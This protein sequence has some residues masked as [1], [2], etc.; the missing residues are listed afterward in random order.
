MILRSLRYS[1][2]ENTPNEWN[3]DSFNLGQIN[4]IVGRNATGKTRTLNVIAS[5]ANLISGDQMEGMPS[6]VLI[7]DIG[8]GLD[9]ERSSLLI[10][11]LIGECKDT[12]I[13]LIM[14][15]NDKFVMNSVPLEYWSVIQRQ[16][17]RC[18]IFN[19]ENSKE[20]FDEMFLQISH[21]KRYPN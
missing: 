10:N 16:G 1:Q 21:I 9:Y 3:I 15:T 2:H 11:Y 18:R 12:S 20:I 14:A 4:L 19:Y 13:Q 8:E 6:C 7:D 5:L 17:G